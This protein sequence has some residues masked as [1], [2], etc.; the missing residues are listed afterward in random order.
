MNGGKGYD[1]TR[2]ARAGRQA[3]YTGL[4]RNGQDLRKALEGA[5]PPMDFKGA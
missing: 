2:L 5:E 3:R 4:I 1:G